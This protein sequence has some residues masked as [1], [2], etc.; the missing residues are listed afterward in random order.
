MVDYTKL[1]EEIAFEQS[2]IDFDAVERDLQKI[3]EILLL[4]KKLDIPF[5]ANHWDLYN[6]GKAIPTTGIKVEIADYTNFD[7][8][9]DL[10]RQLKATGRNIHGWTTIYVPHLVMIT[11]PAVK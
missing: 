8:L 3:K 1:K 5:Y 2:N 10:E 7:D 4:F 11:S 9:L 6:A